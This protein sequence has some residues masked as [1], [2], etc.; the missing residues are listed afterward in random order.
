MSTVSDK[1]QLLES[2]DTKRKEMMDSA[3]AGGYTSSEAVKCSQELDMLLNQ[4]Q[5][6]IFEEENRTTPPFMR[7]I[8]SMKKWTDREGLTI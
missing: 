5:Q 3:R 1:T 7:F 6:I 8:H 4:Y 2:I